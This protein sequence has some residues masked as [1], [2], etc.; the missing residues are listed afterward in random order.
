MYSSYLEL[1]KKNFKWSKEMPMV[2][3]A[4]TYV[5]LSLSMLVF[6]IYILYFI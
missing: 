3:Q 6:W 4:L 2:F 5:L 1:E